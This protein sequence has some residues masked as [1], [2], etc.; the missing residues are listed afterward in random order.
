MRTTRILI[1]LMIPLII[2]AVIACCNCNENTF[3][4]YST[5]WYYTNNDM[6]VSNIDNSG[7]A[8]VAAQSDSVSKCAYGIRVVIDRV[9]LEQDPTSEYSW[10]ALPMPKKTQYR[11][12]LIQSAYAMEECWCEEERILMAADTMVSLEVISNNYFDSGH[13]AG[14]DIQDLFRIFYHDNLFQTS[15]ITNI[16]VWDYYDPDDEIILVLN[17]LLMQEPENSGLNDFT[18]RI[19]LSDGRLFE[20][21]TQ[22]TLI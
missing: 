19:T 15:D 5:Y 14:S 12:G 16:S 6:L 4:N 1:L 9:E 22:I 8:P 3:T 10:R 20:Q 18:V 11:E 7:P 17:L 2:E 21:S 13:P